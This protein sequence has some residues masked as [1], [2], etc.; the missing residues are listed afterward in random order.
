MY[1]PPRRCQVG[2]GGDFRSSGDDGSTQCGSALDAQSTTPT[3]PPL[4]RLP[5][6]LLR[7][8]QKPFVKRGI[9]GSA[10]R[11]RPSWRQGFKGAS[12][13]ASA[14]RNDAFVSHRD[15]GEA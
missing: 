2:V 10:A 9:T 1:H 6:L 4:R 7:I 5:V 12:V 13:R 11:H 14:R 8:L 15:V 3:K